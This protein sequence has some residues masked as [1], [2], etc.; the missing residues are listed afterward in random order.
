[1]GHEIYIGDEIERAI[2]IIGQEA[3]KHNDYELLNQ[4]ADG[5]L[6]VD[7]ELRGNYLHVEIQDD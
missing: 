5:E 1:M 3:E 6:D 4:Y 2:E 7:V